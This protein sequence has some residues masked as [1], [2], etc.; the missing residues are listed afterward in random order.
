KQ[1]EAIAAVN[2][3]TGECVGVIGFS[4]NFNRITWFGVLEKFRGNGIG[5]KLL[6][7]ALSKLDSSKEIT[8]ETFRDNYM[9]GLPARRLYLKH[10]FSETENNL[11]DSLGNE[12]CKLAIKA[13]GLKLFCDIKSEMDTPIVHR[14][15][16]YAAFDGSPEGTRRTVLGYKNNERLHFYGRIENDEILGICGFEEHFDKIE[17][18]L[19]SVDENARGKGV[20]GAMV[21]A[22]K[23]Y[24]KPIEA[25]TDDD[26][27]DFYRKCGF[28]VTVFTHPVRGKRWTCILK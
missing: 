27:V 14:I 13:N 2:G 11:F 3:E 26:A 16:S 25:E 15:I 28:D 17:I 23:K 19:I 18:H 20:G 4:R 12:R 9:P 24:R 22:L 5:D 21:S 1:R 7:L 6:Q 8:V 10:G